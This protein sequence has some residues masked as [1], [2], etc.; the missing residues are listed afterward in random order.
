MKPWLAGLLLASATVARADDTLVIKPHAPAACTDAPEVEVAIELVP[1]GAWLGTSTGARCFV[2]R[3]DQAALDAELATIV[4]SMAPGCST[5]TEIAATPGVAYQDVITVM[6]HAIKAG[7]TE[8]A[9]DD[10][11]SLAVQFADTTA[12]E[13][14]A[15]HCTA[16]PASTAAGAVAPS[17]SKPGATLT[18]APTPK[19]DLAKAPV[20]IVTTTEVT[21]DGAS[22]GAVKALARGKGAIAP[23]VA[24]LKARSAKGPLILQADAS[25]DAAVI[26]RVI[27]SAHQ[28]DFD[29]VLF[30][31]KTK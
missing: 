2:A 13:K 1:R 18:V 22:F 16:K 20:V 10:P 29:D 27:L 30:A 12:K 21:L 5:S 26:N 25:T 3:D 23:L 17:S 11:R 31:V 28:A 4:R 8:V 15:P 24:A 6:D 7:L 14:A 19:P 9:L